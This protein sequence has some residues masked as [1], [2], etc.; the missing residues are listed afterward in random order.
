MW[1]QMLVLEPVSSSMPLVTKLLKRTTVSKL[2]IARPSPL[3]R[4]EGPFPTSST[5]PSGELASSPLLPP[6]PPPPPPLPPLLL[7]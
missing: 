1:H 5:R 7:S 3:P 4:M 6:P 2:S